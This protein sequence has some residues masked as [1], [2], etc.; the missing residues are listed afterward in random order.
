[1]KNLSKMASIMLTLVLIATLFVGCKSNKDNVQ[2]DVYKQG[3]TNKDTQ[4]V[5]ETNDKTEETESV[6]DTV[7]K[8]AALK[9]PTG[10][11]MA[12]LMDAVDAGESS[13]NCE[14][15]ISGKVDDITGKILSKE[16][17]FACIPT[18]LASV[19]YNKS[20]G[21]IKLAAVNTLGVLYV[22]EIG[23]EIESVQ[24]L[25]DKE[26]YTSGKGLVPDYIL[27]YI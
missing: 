17:D 6:N 2:D 18:N 14:F 9:G 5:E 16:V 4:D 22:M 23:N 25:K 10:M 1:M 3:E 24:D 15:S 7:I 20:E 27:Q 19:L 8:V 12:K 13:L 11:G 26:I 21:Q